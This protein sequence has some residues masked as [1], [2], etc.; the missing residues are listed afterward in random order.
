M[1]MIEV[2][3]LNTIKTVE[4]SIAG[5]VKK[6]FCV[7]TDKAANPVNLMGASKRI[8]ELYLSD[9]GQRIS[10]SS[11]RFANVAFSDGSLLHSF[12]ERLKQD[13]PIVAPTDVKRYFVTPKESGILCLMS[14]LFGENGEI[15]FPKLDEKEHLVAFT[16]IADKFLAEKGYQPVYCDSEEQAR[17]T[18]SELKER[19]QWPCFYSASDTTGEK[20]FEEFYMEG[21]KI[22][23]DRYADLGI[24][25]QEMD[26]NKSHLK[27]FKEETERLIEQGRWTK[28]ELI[29][30]FRMLLPQFDYEDKGKYLDAK[31]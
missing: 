4:Q 12:E 27:Q 24:V 11:A 30:L 10:I 18:V 16:E 2:N 7:S 28:E 25:K 6:Y 19:K 14:C 3:I 23:L 26:I 9:L 8:M 17:E 21:E 13:H 20:A 1:R 22:S 31:M 5:G 15:Y 29:S